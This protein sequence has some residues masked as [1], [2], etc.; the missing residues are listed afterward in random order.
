M[1]TI[2]L[3]TALTLGAS[4]LH[5]QN[6][7]NR[8]GI[9]G[10]P[11]AAPGNAAPT[12]LPDKP[13]ADSGGGK[14]SEKNADARFIQKAGKGGKMAVK[15]AEHAINRASREDLKAYSSML[16]KDH[17]AANNELAAIATELGVEIPEPSHDSG[18][19]ESD[20]AKSAGSSPGQ[21]PS[22]SSQKDD[23]TEAGK[24]RMLLEKS[25]PEFDTAYMEMVGECH[26]RD[27]AL[28]EKFQTEVQSAKLKAFIGRTLPALKTH[29]TA[30]AA[31]ERKDPSRPD[32]KTGSP[33]PAV[34]GATD[35]SQ[36]RTDGTT[37]NR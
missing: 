37:P 18:H 29:A 35:P 8:E 11:D 25:G 3:C 23:S 31:L 17:T 13:P 14:A 34:P 27:I 7:P 2:L 10:V 20:T 12:A 9:G 4:V 32:A 30:L 6:A 21:K 1:K 5:A 24:H 22:D 15:M 16:V 33:A 19:A 28:F 26:R 36:P